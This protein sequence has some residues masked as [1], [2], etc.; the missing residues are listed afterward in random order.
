[1]FESKLVH[2]GRWPLGENENRIVT[3]RWSNVGSRQLYESGWSG[4][5]VCQGFY[6]VGRQC[7]GCSFFAPFD[8]DWGLCA[9]AKSR[10]WLETVFEHFTCPAHV[11]EG[12]GPHS[13]TEDAQFH[14]LC[15]GEADYWAA[16]VAAF[17]ASQKPRDSDQGAQG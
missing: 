7:G 8:S 3:A 11:N 15:G 1:M 10:H 17:E 2:C 13:F 6:D 14:C 4:E 12:W 9:H 16:I 5:P